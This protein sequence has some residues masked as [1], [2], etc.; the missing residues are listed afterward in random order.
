MKK[1]LYIVKYAVFTLN[2]LSLIPPPFIFQNPIVSVF[3]VLV[4]DTLK[5][6]YDSKA[7][8]KY[9]FILY[10][11]IYELNDMLCIYFKRIYDIHI[12][13][14]PTFVPNHLFTLPCKSIKTLYFC[15]VV[16]ME[17]YFSLFS[18]R[19]CVTITMQSDCDAMRCDT[20]AGGICAFICQTPDTS[21]SSAVR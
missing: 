7:N 10:Q 6:L 1:T 11:C 12:Y 2:L 4:F 17:L 19:K 14:Q 13:L 8:H 20:N 16:C 15:T 18:K 9:V 21:S 3:S 5:S